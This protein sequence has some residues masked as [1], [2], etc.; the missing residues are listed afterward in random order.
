MRVSVNNPYLLGKKKE[1]K[2][3][4]GLS[5]LKKEAASTLVFNDSHAGMIISGVEKRRFV[6]VFVCFLISTR[7]VVVF[8]LL[9]TGGNPSA[10]RLLTLRRRLSL[11]FVAEIKKRISHFLASITCSD[12]KNEKGDIIVRLRRSMEQCEHVAS[13]CV[14]AACSW[15][16]F[17][18]NLFLPTKTAAP[19]VSSCGRYYCCCNRSL[20]SAF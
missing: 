8:L 5:W 3:G 12:Q 18:L 11:C 19:A 1:K 16:L 2:R 15:Y 10:F 4:D 7:D 17:T 14:R 20:C 13:C 9:A 6:Y